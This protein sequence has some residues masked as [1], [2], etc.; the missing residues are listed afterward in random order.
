MPLDDSPR[1][2]ENVALLRA[3]VGGFVARP[4]HP[5]ADARQFEQLALGLIDLLDADAAAAVL[6]PLLIHPEAPEAVF[7]RLRAKG[8]ACAALAVELAPRVAAADLIDAL[9]RPELSRAAARRGDLD[10]ASMGALAL[11][12]D[13][14]TLRA[15]AANLALRFDPATRRTLLRAARDDRG[16]ARLLLDRGDF[17]ADRAA[18]FLAATRAERRTIVLDARARAGAFDG[19]PVV[20]PAMVD[21]FEAAA[22]RGDR[23]EMATILAEVF[24]C[25]KERARALFLD[26]QGEPLALALA[27]LGVS[28]AKATRI[29][30][31]VETLISHDAVRV[32][33][34]AA[35]A[36]AIPQH[37]AAG[38]IAAM[39]GAESFAREAAGNPFQR[40]AE[41]VRDS[42]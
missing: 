15:L 22:L 6:R 31:S 38:L 30:R 5:V 36:R 2:A 4:T 32:R 20:H 39:T 27:A 18:L 17:D 11:R 33:G 42:A 25:E 40:L 23:A 19:E 41:P 1:Q 24:G 28:P 29:F 35:M 10:P 21:R 26:R 9:R 8:G 13:M 12:G 16:L 3:I 7:E 34:L 37:V 14:E